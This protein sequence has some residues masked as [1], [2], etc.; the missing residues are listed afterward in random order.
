MKND[1][2]ATDPRAQLAPMSPYLEKIALRSLAFCGF[3][4]YSFTDTRSSHPM[5]STSDISLSSIKSAIPVRFRL[6]V[7]RLLLS[8]PMWVAALPSL[9]TCT[10]AG[11][12]LTRISWVSST[13]TCAASFEFS[14]LLTHSTL[15][16][17][18]S[19][20]RLESSIT[21]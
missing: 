6:E 3:T 1:R 2:T 13:C 12:A 11:T 7:A 14:S 5:E 8:T 10:E 19:P 4:L 16:S 17:P 21:S 15:F 9:S 20:C 18:S